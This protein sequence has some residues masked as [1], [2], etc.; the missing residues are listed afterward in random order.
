MRKIENLIHATQLAIVILLWLLGSVTVVIV[1]V[2]VTL[3][4][5]LI[6]SIGALIFFSEAKKRYIASRTIDK[7]MVAAKKKTD[8]A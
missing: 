3:V 2:V 5:L 8:A 7:M 4:G 1:P 6:L